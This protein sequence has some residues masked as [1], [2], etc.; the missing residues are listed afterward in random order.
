MRR[1]GNYILKPFAKDKC[2]LLI[3]E[4][5]IKEQMKNANYVR[6]KGTFHCVNVKLIYKA[7][8]SRFSY[9]ITSN[10]NDY[11]ITNTIYNTI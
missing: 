9:E 6:E 2:K 10:L 7:A 11:T 5:S 8:S 1:I 3:N 4:Y